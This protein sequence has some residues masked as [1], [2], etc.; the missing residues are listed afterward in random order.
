MDWPGICTT[1]RKV[2]NGLSLLTYISPVLRFGHCFS[3]FA[4]LKYEVV[5]HISAVLTEALSQG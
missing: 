4:G 1:M 2:T 5:A 3:Y